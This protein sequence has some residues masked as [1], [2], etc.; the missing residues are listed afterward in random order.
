MT[1]CYKAK[2]LATEA[3]FARRLLETNPTVESQAKLPRQVLQAA[4]KNMTDASQ[5]NYDFRNPFVTCGATYV[6]IYRGQKDV[7]CLTVAHGLCQAKKGSSVLFVILQW[8]VQM[9]RGYYVL[10]LRFDNQAA[11]LGGFILF[12]AVAVVSI[13]L[14]LPVN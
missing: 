3:N 6:P 13:D 11:G 9:L 5:L 7:S 8:L 1:V 14:Y 12:A 10:H 4:E 2:N